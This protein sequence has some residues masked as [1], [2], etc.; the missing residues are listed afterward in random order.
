MSGENVEIVERAIAAINAR[1][2][3]DYL[4]CCTDDVVLQ[5]PMAEMTGVYE[6]PEGINQLSI[7]TIRRQTFASVSTAWNRSARVR[8]WPSCK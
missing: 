4:A 8:S 5:T 6:G 1:D 3:D 7:S 2:I